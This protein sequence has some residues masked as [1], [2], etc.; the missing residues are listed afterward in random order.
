[1]CHFDLLV[2]CSEYSLAEQDFKVAIALYRELADVRAEA[3]CMRCLGDLYFVQVQ[4]CLQLNV[5]L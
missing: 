3:T 1:M 4:W 5:T 2:V